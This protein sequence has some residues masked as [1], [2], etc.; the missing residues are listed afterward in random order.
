MPTER[1]TLVFYLD[2]QRRSALAILDGL[3]ERA[4]RQAVVPSGWT[5]IE[6]IRHLGGEP[7]GTGS[8]PS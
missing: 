1:D 8:G 5:P 4:L 2:A 7:N 3:D 6:L